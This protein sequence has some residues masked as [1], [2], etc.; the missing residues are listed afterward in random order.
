VKNL[1]SKFLLS[2]STCTAT[3]SAAARAQ[4]EDGVN[5][6]GRAPDMMDCKTKKER[7]KKE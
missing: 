4:E 5:N 3:P 7:E 2:N 6:A 1:V